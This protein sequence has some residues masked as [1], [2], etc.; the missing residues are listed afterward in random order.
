MHLLIVHHEEEIGRALQALVR[1]YTA[2]TA[3]YVASDE[4]ALE[5]A[6][7]NAECGLLVTQL[8]SEGVDGLTMAGSLGERFSHLH[9]FFLPPYPLDTQRLQVAN[10]KIFPEPIDGERLLQAIERT[11]DSPGTPDL[12]HIIDLLQMCCLSGKSGGVQ[13]VVGSEAGV[14]YLRNGELRH[15]ETQRAR[16]LDAIFEMLRWG[17]AEFAYDANAS[18]AEQSI[19]IGWDAALI[20]VV[21]R[22]REERALQPGGAESEIS[23]TLLPPEPDLTGEQFGTY[24]V[25]QKLTESFW[26]KVYQAEQTSI[27]RS[28][29]LHVLRSSLR[30]SPERAQEFLDTA[31]AN[32]NIR[33]PSILPV[34]EAGEFEGTYFYARE[35]VV[36]RTVYEIK[37]RGH[38]IPETTALRIVRAI[39]EALAHLDDHGI[40]HAPLRLSRIFV[41]PNDE[42][43]LA[44][45][46]V[47]NPAMAQL[48]PSQSE[49]QMVGRVLIPMTKATAIPGSGRV[50][51][52][53]HRMQTSGEDALTTWRELAEEAKKLATMVGPPPPVLSPK[54]TGVF[55][56]VKFWGR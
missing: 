18:P 5:W 50:L 23:T 40:M 8:E 42:C 38:T 55:E 51:T 33:H 10:T 15:A 21:M 30:Q 47:A 2:Q 49:I 39:A 46:A 7:Q 52:L 31:S 54:K 19:D 32:A 14:V 41:T 36:G 56:K 53:I 6:G 4:A 1:E 13:L 34:Y 26:D 20:E 22:E 24:L 44:D 9:T 11:A 35:F 25:G 37:A 16:G 45:V 12:F 28:V 43:R 27:G 3:N 29:V 17:H 48:A